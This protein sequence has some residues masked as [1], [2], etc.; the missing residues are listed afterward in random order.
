MLSLS[1]S[2]FCLS[3]SFSFHHSL[4][5]F[6]FS[7]FLFYSIFSLL[8]IF[9]LFHFS[10]RRLLSL[11]LYLHISFSFLLYSISFV[12]FTLSSFLLF[13][14]SSTFPLISLSHSYI[15]NFC[16]SSLGLTA[17]SVLRELQSSSHNPESPVSCLKGLQETSEIRRVSLE[18]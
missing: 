12:S 15:T 8:S 4:S 9:I 14:F 2:L 10:F 13:I 7:S 17:F 18:P 3:L 11:F 5:H 6:S 1:K 16:F